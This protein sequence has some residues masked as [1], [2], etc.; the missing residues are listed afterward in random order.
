[1]Y[2]YKIFSGETLSLDEFTFSD[3]KKILKTSYGDEV[4]TVNF[5]ETLLEILQKNSQKDRNFF[6]NLNVCD[7]LNV[8]IEMRANSMGNIASVV[9]P[10]DETQLRVDLRLDWI[11]EDVRE[12]LQFCKNQFVE[13][14]GIRLYF[15]VPSLTKLMSIVS[16]DE[17]FLCFIERAEVTSLSD[18]T[19]EILTIEDAKRVLN[20]ISAKNGKAIIDGFQSIVAGAQEQNFLKRYKIETNEKLKFVPSISSLLWYTKLMFNE[21]LDS[22]YHNIFMLAKYGNID[23][24]YLEKCTPGEYTYFVKKLEESLMA[25]N[26]NSD[27]SPSESV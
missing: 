17:Q 20:M 1:M 12:F 19:F 23:P 26:G 21:P 24:N 4:V 10:K 9:V 16:D 27:Q 6:L 3:Y 18:K 13:F 7:I 14:E 11:Q 2:S 5:V 22:L 15:G 25:E 8:L